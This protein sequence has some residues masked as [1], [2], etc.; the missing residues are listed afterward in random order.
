MH[1]EGDKIVVSTE[2]ASGGEKRHEMRYILAISLSLV[3]ALFGIIYA[4]GVFSSD[5]PDNNN[6]SMPRTTG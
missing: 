6:A 2:E 4:A 1:H 3:I 5:D